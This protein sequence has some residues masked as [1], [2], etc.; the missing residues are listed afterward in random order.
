MS[1]IT[2]SP[3]STGKEIMSAV[4]RDSPELKGEAADTPRRPALQRDWLGEGQLGALTLQKWWRV[5]LG[6]PSGITTTF[7][8]CKVK[9]ALAFSKLVA[10]WLATGAK[11]NVWKEKST[12]FY[13]SSMQ[14]GGIPHKCCISYLILLI[15]PS[16]HSLCLQRYAR[17]RQWWWKLIKCCTM[18]GPVL[19]MLSLACVNKHADRRWG[20]RYVVAT[21][22][23]QRS[24]PCQP[25]LCRPKNDRIWCN[26]LSIPERFLHP[27]PTSE[28]WTRFFC[29][30]GFCA[31]RS[32]SFFS[33][34]WSFQCT[35]MWTEWKDAVSSLVT[36]RKFT[37][38]ITADC[39]EGSIFKT[40]PPPAGFNTLVAV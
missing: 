13:L 39:F 36:R 21:Q 30:H 14:A 24:Q 27:T 26:M 25:T 19:E 35:K 9:A 1:G 33:Q 5:E 12:D 34:H 3:A 11:A 23:W 28:R 10:Y 2:A 16:I 32:Q 6:P 22:H 20:C 29:V 17:R 37:I 7:C 15:H 40:G 4:A 18:G 38:K 31:N 8:L